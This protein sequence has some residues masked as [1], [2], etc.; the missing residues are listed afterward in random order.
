MNKE[1]IV[2]KD[3]TV[4]LSELKGKVKKFVGDRNWEQYHSPKNLAMS[5]SIEAAELMEEFQ[6]VDIHESRNIKETGDFDNIKE[7]IA[8]IMIYCLSFSNSLDIDV[9][10]AIIKKIEKNENR[11]PKP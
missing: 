6:W 9:A 10:D 2:L 7:E 11:F 3:S 1:L 4:T 5:I 8:D